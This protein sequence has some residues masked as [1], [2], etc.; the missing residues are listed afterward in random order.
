MTDWEEARFDQIVELARVLFDVPIA[1][2]TLVD[3]D[4]QW[5]KA[6][7]GLGVR[8]TDR[9]VAFCAHAIQEDTIFVVEDALED[10]RFRDNPLVTGEPHIRF[11]AGAIL[12]SVNGYP[13]GTLCIIDR[14]PRKFSRADQTKLISLSKFVA[15]ELRMDPLTEVHR[16]KARLAASIDPLTGL[17]EAGAFRER[18]QSLAEEGAENAG[19]SLLSVK[20][21]NLAAIKQRLQPTIADE[22]LIDVCDR[23]IGIMRRYIHLGGR[24]GSDRLAFVVSRAALNDDNVLDEVLNA[25]TAPVDTSM[26]AVSPSAVFYTLECGRGFVGVDEVLLLADRV[27]ET[28]QGCGLICIPETLVQQAA[29][30]LRLARKVR[31]AMDDGAIDLYYQPKICGETLKIYGFEALTRWGDPAL[32][33]IPADHAVAAIDDAGLLREYTYWT[34]DRACADMADWLAAMEGR[35]LSVSVNIPSE[36][37]SVPQ[38]ARSAAEILEKYDL[39]AGAIEFEILE[40]SLVEETFVAAENMRYLAGL[41]VTFS[42]DDFGTGYSSLSYIAKLPLHSIKIDRDFVRQ[43]SGQRETDFL[44]QSIIAIARNAGLEVVA[45][46][47]ETERQLAIL[48]EMGCECLQGYLF[49][50]AVS[51]QEVPALLCDNHHY[52]RLLETAS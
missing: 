14:K 10:V 25:V 33:A 2:V 37:M 35:E 43:L 9:D 46:G 39:P 20:F 16:Q 30:A 41:G 36:L 24:V 7:C 50:P 5:F 29:Y 12:K 42:I 45:E 44:V 22:V 4:R 28:A 17:Y 23:I 8:E 38:F 51:R 18:F 15:D 52:K 27:G 49:S 40:G 34:I 31:S 26:G 13:L 48:R 6:R 32:G 19:Y 21:F 1:L 47:V 3:R 11:Y